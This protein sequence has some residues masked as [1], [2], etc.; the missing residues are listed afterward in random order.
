MNAAR[1]GVL[2]V[3][4]VAVVVLLAF[5]AFYAPSYFVSR[6][7]GDRAIM[8]SAFLNGSAPGLRLDLQVTPGG[9]GTYRIIVKE[10]NTM[11]ANNSVPSADNWAYPEANLIP[12]A[13]CDTG[14][15]PVGLAVLQ[16]RYTLA[17]YSQ[18]KPLTLY[19]TTYFSSCTTQA[20]T[21]AQWVFATNSSQASFV[22]PP[23][24][25]MENWNITTSI[26]AA[27]YWTGGAGTQQPATLHSFHGDYTVLAA[28]EWGALGLAYFTVN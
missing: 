10:L 11:S 27:G 20:Y 5:S 3:A 2:T 24:G 21:I 13:P 12:F 23:S 7:N 1:K 19:N 8:T 26:L 14:L 18:A 25:R 28:D 9:N 15:F 22:Y 16:G 6:S 4:I 17:N